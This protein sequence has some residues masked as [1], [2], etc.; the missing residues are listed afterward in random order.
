MS[1]L[2][3]YA[4][5]TTFQLWIYSAVISLGLGVIFGVLRSKNVKIPGVF[6]ILNVF[7]F[8]LRGVP[9]YV[10]LLLAYFVLPEL[11]GINPPAFI[12]A[13]L[14]LG[15]CSAAY[16]SQIMR[17]GLNSIS[18][19]Q[20]ESAQVLGYTKFQTLR[21][22]IMPQVFKNVLPAINGE[23]DQLLKSTSIVS[24]IGVLE[25]TRAALNVIAVEMQ[26]I[27]VYLSIA[28]IYL[29]MSTGLTFLTNKMERLF[30]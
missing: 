3:L 22:I 14:S 13:F 16:V 11:L 9:Y 23:L 18:Q 17:A 6:E 24:A 1:L 21:Y 4:A 19:G 12:C 27:P 10:Q 28:L 5:F 7:T 30:V 2:F 15:L 25:L 26:P 20:W 8:V 29:A